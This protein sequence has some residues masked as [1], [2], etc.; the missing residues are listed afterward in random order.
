LLQKAAL[1]ERLGPRGLVKWLGRQMAQ[2][3]SFDD[4]QQVRL[5]RDD[6]AVRVVTIHKAKGLEYEIVFCPLLIRGGD[7]LKEIRFHAERDRALTVDVA[8][9]D[10]ETHRTLAEREAL[11]DDVRKIYVALTRAKQRCDFVWGHHKEA[12]ISALGW[13]MHPPPDPVGFTLD[14]LREHMGA[15]TPGHRQAELAALVEKAGGAIALHPVPSPAAPRYRAHQPP[16]ESLTA[17]KFKGHIARDY[18]V[19][20]F[21]SLTESHDAE[22]PDYDFPRPE[23][24]APESEAAPEGIHALPGGTRTGNCVHEIF[25]DLEFTD[26]AAIEPL[27]KSKLLA[28][29]F[30]P[31]K[32]GKTVSE[33]VRHTLQARLQDGFRLADLSPESRLAELEFFLPAGR[34]EAE[35][36]RELL[37]VE[38]LDFSPRQGWLKGFIDLLA[39][40]QGR[41][42]I[43]DWKTN[44]LGDRGSAYAAPSL[45]A[46]MSAHRYSLQLHL[47][48]LAVHRYLR[49]R[50]PGYDYD[51]HF[52]GAYYLFLRG[53]DPRQPE[54]GV[55]RG[56]PEA[57]TIGAL[58]TWLAGAEADPF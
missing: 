54:L 5:D 25:E 35:R 29:A 24:L 32:W 28:F 56:R 8:S 15:L 14:T 18:C 37:R 9:P 3:D 38:G 11:A 45:A 19:S 55:Y 4:E 42:Y 36:L 48:T 31:E 26:D 58:E 23:V 52:G 7:G 2:S 21:S 17:R 57:Q 53:I 44:R 49:Q 46:A 34:L 6:A 47:Y 13:L 27:V 12:D 1:E 10:R 22:V 51:T 41:Y 20:S 39:V 30:P 40:Y 43:F 33:C 16:P 50:V